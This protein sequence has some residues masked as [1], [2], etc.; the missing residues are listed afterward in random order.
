[1][2]SSVAGSRDAPAILKKYSD[3]A[4][5]PFRIRPHHFKIPKR[6]RNYQAH[7][8]D[9]PVELLENTLGSLRAWQQKM[10][11]S[12]LQQVIDNIEA[13]LDSTFP[14]AQQAPLQS[15]AT[16]IISYHLFIT[17]IFPQILI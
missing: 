1:M 6:L 10:S 11:S 12:E 9:I 14:S 7:G 16:S 2:N 5:N 3:G 4:P 17:F 13:L 8:T 15:R